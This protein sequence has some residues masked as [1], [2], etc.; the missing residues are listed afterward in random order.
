MCASSTGR[1]SISA[2]LRW[3]SAGTGPGGTNQWCSGWGRFGRGDSPACDKPADIRALASELPETQ[4]NDNGKE[5]SCVGQ[6]WQREVWAEMTYSV[7]LGL[8]GFWAN[9]TALLMSPSLS[10]GRSVGAVGCLHLILLIWGLPSP[11]CLLFSGPSCWAMGRVGG[12]LSNILS[13]LPTARS[14]P[15]LLSSRR[16]IWDWLN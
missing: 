7:C 1:A 12:F 9:R 14:I 13:V 2:V 10:L 8:E 4:I 6:P 3:G 11:Q 15:Q 5:K 16:G